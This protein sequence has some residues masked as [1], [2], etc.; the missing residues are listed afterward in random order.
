MYSTIGYK[1]K[2]CQ[3]TFEAGLNGNNNNKWVERTND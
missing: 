3:I 1:E 2:D